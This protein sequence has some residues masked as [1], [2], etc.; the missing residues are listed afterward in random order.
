MASGEFSS[1]LALGILPATPSVRPPEG[2]PA[3]DNPEKRSRRR[4]Q[5]PQESDDSPE[6]PEAP[7]H[8][9]DRLA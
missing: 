9:I 4:L 6:A 7:E 8:Q 2:H 1:D 5:K 3:G